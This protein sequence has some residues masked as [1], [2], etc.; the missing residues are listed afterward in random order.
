VNHVPCLYATYIHNMSFSVLLVLLIWD[1][2]F[3]IINITLL[4]FN[5]RYFWTMTFITNFECLSHIISFD[6]TS[7]NLTIFWTNSS[8]TS[9]VN[10]VDLVGKKWAC[11]VSLWIIIKKLSCVFF[12]FWVVSQWNWCLWIHICV[13]DS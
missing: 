1:I 4:E 3:Y 5:V 12:G 11:S 7:C 6:H 10:M 13:R 2:I 9:I 8:A